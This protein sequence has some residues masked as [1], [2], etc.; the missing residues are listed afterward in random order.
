ME[1]LKAFYEQAKAKLNENKETVIKIGA[2]LTGALIGAVVT[3]LV[4]NN[5][6]EDVLPV[7]DDEEDEE[8][9]EDA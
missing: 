5:R 3:A 9:L 8:E 2:A 1:Q 4:V 7:V 6:S